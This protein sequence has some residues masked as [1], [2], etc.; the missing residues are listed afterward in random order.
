MLNVFLKGHWGGWTIP[1][2]ISL[3]QIPTKADNDSYIVGPWAQSYKSKKAIKRAPTTPHRKEKQTTITNRHR[4]KQSH[5]PH[6][7]DMVM[8]VEHCTTS[9]QN[10]K[11]L[12]SRGDYKA[13]SQDDE[14]QPWCTSSM[15]IIRRL[16]PTPL[17]GGSLKDWRTV[18]LRARRYI[19]ERGSWSC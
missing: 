15:E 9:K 8:V 6:N 13:L 11:E 1:T 5:N 12:H 2:W 3:P 10:S 19:Q 14:R 16:P 7:R 4:D 17:E 18:D